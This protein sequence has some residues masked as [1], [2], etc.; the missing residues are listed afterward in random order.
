MK[1]WYLDGYMSAKAHMCIT[2]ALVEVKLRNVPAVFHEPLTRRLE[3]G[4]DSTHDESPSLRSM[5][6]SSF[7]AVPIF[8]I[9]RI[10]CF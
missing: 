7:A 9:T 5:L 3:K 6:A 1:E 8:F 2:Y 4:A 10:S